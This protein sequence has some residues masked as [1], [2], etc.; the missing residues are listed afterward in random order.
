MKLLDWLVVLGYLVGAL[1]LGLALARRGT[2]SIAEFFV[3]G[4][5]IPWWLAATSMAATTFNVDTPLYVAGLVARFGVA[6]NWEWW[7]FAGAH[8]LLAV[9]LARLWRR[10]GVV[11]DAELVE[12]RYAGPTAAALRGTRAF[13]FAVP[14]NCIGIGYAMLAMR[15]VIVALGV[16][17]HFPALP[18]DPRL[19]AVLV[20]VLVT[21]AYTTVSGLWGVVATDFIQ[22]VLAMLGAL[23]VMV[24]ALHEVG[25][26]GALASRFRLAG[27]GNRLAVFPTASDALLPFTTFLGYI[28][29]QWWAFKNSDGGGM[30]VQ[31]LSATA[32][33]RDATRAAHLFNFLN[34]V[35][36]TW[37]WVLVGL[38]ALLI[39]PG[40]ADPEMAYP[41]LM[42]RYLP[43][44]VLGLVVASLI[45][46]FMSSVSTQI[47]WGA[48]YIVN[49]LYG[50]FT[51]VRDERKLLRAARWA[52]VGLTLL[53]AALSF[54][55][56][57]VGQV[58]RILILVGTG[59]GAILLL[60]WF[61]WRIN[62][63]AEVTALVAGLVLAAA[64]IFVPQIGAWSFG[65]KLS[66][67]TFGSMA[68]WLPVLFLTPAEPAERLDA[69]YARARPPGAWGPVRARTGLG[70][71]D[72]LADAARDWVLWVTIILGLTVG[73][74]WVVLR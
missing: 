54:Y 29:I 74:G 26:V 7:S 58:F 60:R 56:V 36:R 39:L 68:L 22:Y 62:A 63:W 50:R 32:T 42:V 71:L 14:L 64:T 31:R 1:A 20:I 61:W 19:W 49:D 35:V 46:A 59:T 23:V 28:G 41:L 44:G 27:A 34:Y 69:F 17:D 16:V 12:L 30:F 57:S 55:M 66:F 40:L 9:L 2:G 53:A 6:G 15:K 11:T 10:V 13:V 48:S 33:E 4:R 38:A 21:L 52:S 72:S 37:P 47:N 73:V 5:T 67:T 70:P 43:T 51:G 45:A 8:V 18:G 24:Y 65:T 25:G 3:G